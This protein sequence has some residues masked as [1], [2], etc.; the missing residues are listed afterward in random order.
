MIAVGVEELEAEVVVQLG[1]ARGIGQGSV[2]HQK[3]IGIG[4]GMYI[5]GKRDGIGLHLPFASGLEVE[6]VKGGGS[7]MAGQSLVR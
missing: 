5:G 1:N 7:T 2:S 6:K 4:K 3:E